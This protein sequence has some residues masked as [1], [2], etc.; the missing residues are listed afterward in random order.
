MPYGLKC[1][2]KGRHKFLR[3][4]ALCWVI[5]TDGGG[6]WSRL[7]VE[8]LSRS[9]RKVRTWVD[10]R[11]LTKFRPGWF[12]EGAAPWDFGSQTRALESAAWLNE[13]YGDKP[14]REHAGSFGEAG[15]S[16]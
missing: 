13:N 9:G 8:G 15:E 2:V 12:A 6:G 5:L 4:G 16:F 1:N 11:D 14:Q 7:F 3:S 10:S